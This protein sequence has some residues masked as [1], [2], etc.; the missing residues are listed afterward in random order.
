MG[1]IQVTE[2]TMHDLHLS[3]SEC[4]ITHN[5]RRQRVR[6]MSQ[7]VL[8]DLVG[9]IAALLGRKALKADAPEPC[10]ER[11]PSTDAH[12]PSSHN[13]RAG[14]EGGR[15]LLAHEAGGWFV[16]PPHADHRPTVSKGEVY[17]LHFLPEETIEFTGH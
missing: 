5:R 10:D 15:W 9:S 2:P 17:V 16:Y 11:D 4:I 1:S 14:D 8:R 7:Q 6:V 12:L 13:P 3:A